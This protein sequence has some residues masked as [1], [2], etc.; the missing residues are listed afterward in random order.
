[1]DQ[2]LRV[3]S[4]DSGWKGDET[5]HKMYNLLVAGLL[6]VLRGCVLVSARR[7]VEQPELV[8]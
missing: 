2:S 6:M 4:E 1:M 7:D 3:V 8:R 5:D